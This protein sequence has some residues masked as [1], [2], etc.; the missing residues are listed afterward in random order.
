MAREPFGVK[1]VLPLKEDKRGVDIVT[2]MR[3]ELIKNPARL[4]WQKSISSIINIFLWAPWYMQ[5]KFVK[6]G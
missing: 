3:L 6:V 1:R 4:E 2:S 5:R